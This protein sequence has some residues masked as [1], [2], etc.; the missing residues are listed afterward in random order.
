MWWLNE[1][2]ASFGAISQVWMKMLPTAMCIGR[3]FAI[4]ATA[5]ICQKHSKKPREKNLKLQKAGR[6]MAQYPDPLHKEVISE[7]LIEGISRYITVI[8]KWWETFLVLAIIK[9]YFRNVVKYNGLYW[10]IKITF[11]SVGTYL[12]HLSYLIIIFNGNWNKKY[13]SNLKYENGWVK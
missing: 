8:M 11:Q 3:L 13:T 2:G 10:D 5:Q 7:K 6:K 4:L 1:R 9:F 12:K